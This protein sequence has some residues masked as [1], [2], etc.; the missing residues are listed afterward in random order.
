MSAARLYYITKTLLNYGLDELIPPKKVPWYGKVG[1]ACL[2]WIKN[3]HKEKPAGLRLRLA[4]QELGPVH[5]YRF[6]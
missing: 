2:F 5:T 3:K 4:L 1:R 6:R